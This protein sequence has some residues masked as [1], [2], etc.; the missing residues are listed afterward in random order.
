MDD[1]K[2]QKS[3]ASKAHSRAPSAKFSQ[4]PKADEESV[5]TKSELPPEESDSELEEED[6]WTAIQKFN[7]L[8]HFEE[9]KQMAAREAER[10]RLM[11]IELDQQ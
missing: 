11:K 6:E 5:I 2:S 7:A 8:L 10:K 4:K 3:Y 9:Q 1:L